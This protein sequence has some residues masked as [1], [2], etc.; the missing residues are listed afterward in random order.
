MSSHT[1]YIS[2]YSKM[3]STADFS[4][5]N[6]FVPPLNTPVRALSPAQEARSILG[7][8]LGDVATT[9]KE[10]GIE[11]ELWPTA[12]SWV[13]G[14]IARNGETVTREGSAEGSWEPTRWL[15]PEVD[16]DAAGLGLFIEGACPGVV[17]PWGDF[18]ERS[19]RCFIFFNMA[20][21]GSELIKMGGELRVG[22]YIG[23]AAPGVKAVTLAGA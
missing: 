23:N 7:S 11:V 1:S 16:D 15:G 10:T 6:T 13:W 5:P 4:G 8:A 20:N 14:V 2:T 9:G 12:E 19:K 21:R 22:D 17:P 3:P 18:V